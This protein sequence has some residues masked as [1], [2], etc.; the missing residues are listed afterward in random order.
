ME[1]RKTLV[2][3]DLA[4]AALMALDLN[5]V[6]SAS[7]DCTTSQAWARAKRCAGPCWKGIRYVSQQMN[8]GF[9][10][11][12]FERSGLRKLRAEKLSSRH[13]RRTTAAIDTTSPRS[14]GVAVRTRRSATGC[15]TAVRWQKAVGST[16]P[17]AIAH[18][19]D[20][21]SR[22]RGKGAAACWPAEGHADSESWPSFL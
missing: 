21:G 12:I 5:N 6:I 3:A 17:G 4:G 8:K 9:A 13:S 22:I 7:A 10:W 1:R 2:L 14:E 20:S 16:R 11:A 19:A 18:C 15:T